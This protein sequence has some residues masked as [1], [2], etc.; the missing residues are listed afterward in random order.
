MGLITPLLNIT[1]P[2]KRPIGE[3][4][5]QSPQNYQDI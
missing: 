3:L 4:S 2:Q 1:K 5:K